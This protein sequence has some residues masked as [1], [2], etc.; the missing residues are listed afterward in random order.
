MAPLLRRGLVD[1][2]PAR[3]VAGSESLS[4]AGVFHWGSRGVLGSENSPSEEGGTSI[5]YLGDPQRPSLD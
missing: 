1:A 4:P 2:R 5:R 3:Q